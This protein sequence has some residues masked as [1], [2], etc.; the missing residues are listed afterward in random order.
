[1]CGTCNDQMSSFCPACS[2]S[3]SDLCPC[4]E[5]CTC[6]NSWLY[7]DDNGNNLTIEEW[8]KLPKD[9]RI[10]ENCQLCNPARLVGGEWIFNE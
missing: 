8:G 10:K 2:D 6:L 7:F 4:N 3:F 9:E 1:M 5:P